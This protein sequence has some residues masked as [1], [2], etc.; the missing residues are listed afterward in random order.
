M[1][2]RCGLL[3]DEEVRRIGTLLRWVGLVRDARGIGAETALGHMRIDKKVKAGRI[4]LVL[5][6]RIGEAF[7][8]ADYDDGALRATLSQHFG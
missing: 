6:K 1:S 3:G 4:R 2:Q 5:L 7:V 8:S